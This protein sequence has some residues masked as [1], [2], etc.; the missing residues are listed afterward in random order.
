MIRL[1]RYPLAWLAASFC[2]GSAAAAA[3]I[4]GI[5]STDNSSSTG[6]QTF[7]HQTSVSPVTTAGNTAEFV[8][9]TQLLNAATYSGGF[10]QVHKRNSSF[11]LAF[12]VE[13]PSNA[14]FTVEIDQLLRG[15]SEISVTSGRGDATGV[16]YLV[17]EDDP[18]DPPGTLSNRTD[19][20][21]STGGVTVD[22]D[23]GDPP[24][25][26]R[27]LVE[28]SDSD[29]LGNYTGTTDFLLDYSTTFSTTTN[30]FFQNNS[31]GSGSV[32]YGLGSLPAND[33]F[34][35]S[36]LGHFLTVRTTFNIPEPSSWLLLSVVSLGAVARRNRRRGCVPGCHG[37]LG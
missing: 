35:Q 34:T 25:S 19:L 16:L 17:R 15:Y 9:T 14:G 23:P 1:L 18:T 6:S 13:D 30:V 32:N 33:P 36:Q 5:T 11:Q 4:T 20:F 27:E 28:A 2:F 37:Y 21:I 3:Q 22:L 31:V 10:A 12:T 7:L 24:A 29:V 8:H 26:A